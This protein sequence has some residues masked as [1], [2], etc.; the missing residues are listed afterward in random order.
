MKMGKSKD[1]GYILV[2]TSGGPETITKVYISAGT[3]LYSTSEM[4]DLEDY[5]FE[6]SPKYKEINYKK[7]LGLWKNKI[8]KYS[9]QLLYVYDEEG[10][11]IY[12]PDLL[13]DENGKAVA[14]ALPE[15]ETAKYYIPE[16]ISEEN[17]Q[18]IDELLEL[19]TYSNNK[20]GRAHV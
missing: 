5:R 1:F 2:S 8:G 9:K 14:Y 3:L 7:F 4:Q 6:I 20:I 17:G 13:Y 18:N 10:N 16:K 19:L 11:P 12:N 15:E